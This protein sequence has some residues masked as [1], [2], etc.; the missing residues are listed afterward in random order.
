MNNE[1]E[2]YKRQVQSVVSYTGLHNKYNNS[3]INSSSLIDTNN[4]F[5]SNCL[6]TASI[7]Y[8][9]IKEA[10]T[11]T[12]IPIIIDD[13]TNIKKYNNIDDYIEVR[14]KQDITP[15]DKKQSINILFDNNKQNDEESI[16]LAYHYAK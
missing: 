3:N 6:F 2:K 10:F 14:S 16:T 9:D 1:I 11:E 7:Q 4:N 8:T 12:I 13:Y 5:S 15:L